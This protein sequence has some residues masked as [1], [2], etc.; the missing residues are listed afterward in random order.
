M[1]VFAGVVLV[2]SVACSRG[3]VSVSGDE[4]KGIKPFKLDVTEVTVAAYAECVKAGK[5]TEPST[6]EKECNWGV[7][8]KD[9]HPVNC[10]DFEQ[11]A[12]YCQTF[13]GKRLPTGPEWEWAASNGGRTKFPWGDSGPDQFKA[14]WK[15]RDGTASVG[16]HP[17][18][19]NSS[20]IQDLSGNVREWTATICPKNSFFQQYQEFQ[21]RGG[22]YWW[23]NEADFRAD[24]SACDVPWKVQSDIGFR[25]AE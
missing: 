21:T 11:A 14:K 8:G 24:A 16:S 4:G 13:R 18:G 6:G 23:G 15:S 17:A 1:R 12:I 7:S 25:C 20:G 3:M 10:V 19:A 2:L 5:C 22:T 9:Q